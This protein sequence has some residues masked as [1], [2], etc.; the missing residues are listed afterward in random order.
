MGMVSG[1]HVFPGFPGFDSET[2]ESKNL[3]MPLLIWLPDPNGR[4]PYHRDLGPL[5]QTNDQPR[6]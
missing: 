2:R 1:F 3:N 4:L 5:A 6:R